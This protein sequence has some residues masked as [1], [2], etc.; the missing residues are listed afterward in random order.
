MKL[1]VFIPP[2]DASFSNE[3]YNLVSQTTLG[4]HTQMTSI[5]KT[6]LCFAFLLIL[7][8][9]LYGQVAFNEAVSGD[10]SDIPGAPTSVN[11]NVGVNS[12]WGTLRAD[13][14]SSDVR[15]YFTFTIAAGQQ[16]T[17]L[18]QQDY[19]DIATGNGANRGFH[20]ISAGATSAIPG[21]TTITGFLGADHF[22]P[23]T[24][25]TDLLPGLGTSTFGEIGFT[26]PLG[27]G[28]YTYVVQNTSDNPSRYELDFL[29]VPEPSSAAILGLFSMLAF[30]RV[31]R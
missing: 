1:L 15:D 7:S 11:F 17:A 29:V 25:G 14:T 24:A 22:D 16:L 9:A 19:S 20:A 3:N 30:R 12:V 8:P 26:G 28:T 27:P 6:V 10:L 4:E 2:L 31:R 23:V 21:S 13:A 5:K 18:L